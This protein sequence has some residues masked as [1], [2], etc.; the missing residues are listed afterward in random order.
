MDSHADWSRDFLLYQAYLRLVKKVTEELRSDLPEGYM[1]AALGIYA[2]PESGP[3]LCTILPT[4]PFHAFAAKEST[5]ERVSLSWNQLK[6]E[7]ISFWQKRLNPRIS[8]LYSSMR[9]SPQL[10][11][12]C[13]AYIKHGV[14]KQDQCSDEHLGTEYTQQAYNSRTE[15]VVNL[16][17]LL[18]SAKLLLWDLRNDTLQRDNSYILISKL[19]S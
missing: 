3:D 17:T 6:P 19:P 10:R 11:S 18:R 4:S 8:A 7:V 16:F 2:D 14:C 9:Q 12:P 1:Q 13:P 5:S 15:I